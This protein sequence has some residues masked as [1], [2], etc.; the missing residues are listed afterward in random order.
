MVLDGILSAD[1][2]SAPESTGGAGGSL[3][4]KVGVLSGTGSLQANGGIGKC[5]NSGGFGGGGGR[6]AL[7][8]REAAGFDLSRVT[9][10][11]GNSPCNDSG[12]IYRNGG[13]GTVYLKGKDQE[14][15]DLIVDNLN[16]ATPA[17][18]TSLP[19]VGVGFNTALEANVLT[20]SANPFLP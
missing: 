20:N 6:V 9:A 14:Y 2:E 17:G 12:Q 10:Y 15:G 16:R 18:S 3:W 8:Y 1:G 19:A 4:V 11:G 13:A 7:Y 5:Y